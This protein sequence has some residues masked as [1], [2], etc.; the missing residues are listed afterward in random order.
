MKILD[1]L[2]A[3]YS[4][5]KRYDFQAYGVEKNAF[6]EPLSVSI[7]CLVNVSFDSQLTSRKNK[8]MLNS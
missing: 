2:G 7:V 4:N 5:E 8:P 6:E 1:I 3:L